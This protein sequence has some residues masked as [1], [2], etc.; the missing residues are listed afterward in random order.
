VVVDGA[1]VGAVAS[2]A[3]TQVTSTHT[4][5]AQF[6]TGAVA[7]RTLIV[8]GN[9]LWMDTGM[10]VA[11]GD[12]LTFAAHGTVA[13][14]KRGNSCGPGGTSWTDVQDKKDPLWQK[15][16]AGLIGKIEGSGMPFFIGTAATIK[17]GGNGKL[18]LGIN[19]YWYQGNTGEFTIT[20]RIAKVS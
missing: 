13:Y 1:S 9:T 7:E 20:I 5:A 10:V 19:D 14:D 11:A 2:Y 8:P 18:F 6:Q 16:H 4:I 15:P 12:T 17:A 3:F